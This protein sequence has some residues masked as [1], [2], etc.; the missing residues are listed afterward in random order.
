MIKEH[1]PVR[2]YRELERGEQTVIAADPAESHDFCAAT[3]L[4]KKHYDYPVVFS[5]IM[6]SS[7][8]GYELNSL[9]KYV[10]SKTQM[11]PKLAV[12]RNTGQATIFVLKTLNYPN[13]F[14]MVDFTAQ[15]SHEG[16]GIGWVTT[17]H[18]SG[19][20]LMGTRRKMF[21]DFALVLR[22]GLIKMYD[23]EQIRQ[24]KSFMLVKGRGQQRSNKKDDQ[25]I[26]GSMAWGVHLVTPNETLDDLDYHEE[27]ER[28]RR[29]W[30]FK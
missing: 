19:G 14:R 28:Q 18:W 10:Y 9:A 22:Q 4:S 7:Q 26:A 11:W 6:E 25:V 2:I 15:S 3:V 1:Y 20:E 24:F 17:G 27:F 5:E 12:E 29:K 23:E 30:R 13:L 16:G 21:D 8:F